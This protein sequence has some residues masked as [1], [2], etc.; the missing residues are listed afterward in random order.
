ML[1]EWRDR[2]LQLEEA[3]ILQPEEAAIAR[4][5]YC[6]YTGVRR[7]ESQARKHAP[8]ESHDDFYD[9]D[10]HAPIAD[11][12][13]QMCFDY[14]KLHSEQINPLY[15]MGFNRVGCAPCINSSREDI[16]MWLIKRP[17]MI[18]KVRRLE[19][20]TGRTF[21]SPMVPGRAMNDIDTV[22]NWALTIKRGG[23]EHQPAFPIFMERPACESKYGLC[24]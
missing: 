6:R 17:E 11:W 16:L 19:A 12:S 5:E 4:V 21:F 18:E 20:E 13:K 10:L 14:V 2:M 23:S 1:N 22:L 3:G 24:E 7:E 15:A 9:C 8:I